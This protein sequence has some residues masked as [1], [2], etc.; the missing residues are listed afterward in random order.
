MLRAFLVLV[1]LLAAAP[2]WANDPPCDDGPWFLDKS[3]PHHQLMTGSLMVPV[4][5][6]V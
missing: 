3:Q 1:F 5:T 2:A 6:P 4:A